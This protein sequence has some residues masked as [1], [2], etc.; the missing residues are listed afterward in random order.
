MRTV[1][2]DEGQAAAAASA[3]EIRSVFMRPP[4]ARTSRGRAAVRERLAEESPRLVRPQGEAVRAIRRRGRDC[5]PAVSAVREAPATPG[6]LRACRVEAGEVALPGPL[7]VEVKR[8]R[9]P[10]RCAPYLQPPRRRSSQCWEPRIRWP[11]SPSGI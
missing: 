9:A 6:L 8:R 11:L 10:D 1:L 5:Q 2:A 7:P 4:P 3:A